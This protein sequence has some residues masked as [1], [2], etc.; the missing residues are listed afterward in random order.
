MS[1]IIL[2]PTVAALSDE[3]GLITA[4]IKRLTAQKENISA[5]LK[6]LGAGLYFGHTHKTLVYY[7]K[8]QAVVNWKAV[9]EHMKPSRQLITA[10]TSEK[11]GFLSAKPSLI[12]A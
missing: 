2:T 5:E 9:A 7:T 12:D 8:A 6:L 10:H 4:E 11:A 1:E 3:L